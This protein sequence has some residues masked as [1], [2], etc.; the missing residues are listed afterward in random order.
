MLLSVILSKP[1]EKIKPKS[2]GLWHEYKYL[3]LGFKNI[4]KLGSIKIEPIIDIYKFIDGNPENFDLI[5]LMA[6]EGDITKIMEGD[7]TSKN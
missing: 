2:G 6:E 4:K 1:F 7:I 3:D 5:K